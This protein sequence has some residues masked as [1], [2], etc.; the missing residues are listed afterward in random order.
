VT[1]V[2]RFD[3]FVLYPLLCPIVLLIAGNDG[4]GFDPPGW[5]DSFMYLGYFWHYP[6]HLW[7][8]DDNSNYK[9]SRLPWLLPGVAAHSLFPPVMAAGVLAY[10]SLASAAV[11][12]YLHVR[13]AIDD[14]HA[15][16]FVSVL[17][18][19]CAGM[20]APGGWYYHALP[21]A[22]YYLWS[23]W[24][25]TR[26]ASARRRAPMWAAAAG[27]GLA[28]AVHTHIFLAVFTPLLALLY[29]GALDIESGRRWARWLTATASALAG[30]IG[31]TVV[32]AVINR[33]TGGEWLFFLP[34][35]EIALKLSAFDSWWLPADQWLPHA[36]YLVLPLAMIVLGLT[37]GYGPWKP[38]ERLKG[39]LVV[40]PCLALALTCVFQFWTRETTLD[41]DYMA[42][43]LYL[44]AFPAA[45]VAVS[46]PAEASRRRTALLVLSTVLVLGFLL[47]FMPSRLPSVMGILVERVGLANAPRIVPP[48]LLSLLAIVIARGVPTRFRMAVIA[49]WFAIVNSW[50]APQPQAYGVGTA[51][52]RQQMLET[53][54]EADIFTHRLDPTL[55]GIKYWMSSE[56]L[57]TANGTLP[58]QQVFDSFVATRAWLTNLFAR[59]SPG[60]AIELLTRDHLA[61][62][63]CLGI[64]SSRERQQPLTEQMIDHYASLQQPL[65]VVAARQFQ[66]GDFAFALTVLKAGESGGGSFACVPAAD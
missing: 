8:F 54:R 50:I 22:G 33:A 3:T 49:V 53:F 10:C 66:R 40:L 58:S 44:H 32:L 4:F 11:A 1:R 27:A 47:A 26:A 24:L 37:S 2:R 55:I 57:P 36:T 61:R 43:V 18:A 15:A 52:P 5:L 38:G 17:L 45:A 14:R 39:T 21:A 60:M 12:L 65:F 31:L 59:Q 56:S 16:A 13:D 9:I 7:L 6:E 62:A 20:H 48:L 64:L 30:G 35:L 25:F 23:C 19:A 41:Y 46:V 51:G 42:F 63:S 29:W 34:Q 28:A